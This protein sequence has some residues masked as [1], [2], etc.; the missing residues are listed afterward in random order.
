MKKAP[1]KNKNVIKKPLP[2][3]QSWIKKVLFA[4]LAT[5]P[6][7][8]AIVAI[9]QSDLLRP[10]FYKTPVISQLVEAPCTPNVIWSEH[11]GV[12]GISGLH[13][14]L[15]AQ[16]LNPNAHNLIINKIMIDLGSYDIR[17]KTIYDGAVETPLPEVLI[18]HPISNNSL[19]GECTDL[20]IYSSSGE[21]QL[22]NFPLILTPNNKLRVLIV[23]TLK[24]GTFD[25]YPANDNAYA[26]RLLDMTMPLFFGFDGANIDN[27]KRYGIP[28]RNIDLT[29]V[30][31]K[32]V[33]N[34][35]LWT[36]FIF[37]GT[38][39]VIPD[40]YYD[41]NGKKRSGKELIDYMK[42]FELKD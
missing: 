33:F 11:K 18:T 5:I 1:K 16:M 37:E 28:Q 20:Y 22:T 32:R 3:K 25:L 30:T 14:A 24:F 13:Y 29:F 2:K 19:K 41:L 34:I 39:L 6:V 8:A 26:R 36:E 7:A 31:E 38:R 40:F 35:P 15:R 27:L 23:F 21:P 4:V 42:Q 10:Y 12:L 9:V 17:G